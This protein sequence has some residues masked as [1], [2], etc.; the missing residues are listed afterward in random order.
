MSIKEF[1][2]AIKEWD[3]DAEFWAYSEK[4]GL[5]F[6]SK[7]WKVEYFDGN[8]TQINPHIA[9]KITEKKRGRR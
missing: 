4:D 6:Q 9:P 7:G 1:V 8:K 5:A 3:K 2:K